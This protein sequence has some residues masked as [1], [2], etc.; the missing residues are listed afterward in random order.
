MEILLEWAGLFSREI[1][2]TSLSV[3][4]SSYRKCD[5]AT[6]THVW[7]TEVS[8]VTTIL[9]HPF[10]KVSWQK[11]SRQSSIRQESALAWPQWHMALQRWTELFDLKY[12][13]NEA[14]M[15]SLLLSR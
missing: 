5:P 4:F 14:E 7:V 12:C 13:K 2:Y 15:A 1:A 6:L 9:T 3:H 8:V 10:R 11:E